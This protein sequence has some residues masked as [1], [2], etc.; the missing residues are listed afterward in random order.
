MKR[1]ALC[2]ML[3]VGLA[4][5]LA[6][7]ATAKDKGDGSH[8]DRRPGTVLYKF[9][10][11]LSTDARAAFAQAL[12][13]R[14]M[15]LDRHLVNGK[16]L[17]VK[18]GN[19]NLETEEQ[20]AEALERSGAVEW[21]EP[22]YVEEAVATPNDPYYANQ[23]QHVNIR[24]TGAWDLTTGGTDVLIA[25]CDTGVDLDHPDLL[26]NLALPGWNTYLNTT[27]CNDT[28]GHGT[29]VAGFAAA[30]GNNGIG[31]A[32][33]AWKVKI[34]PIRITFADGGGSAYVSDIAEAIT[35]GAN[36]GAKVVNVSFSGYSSSAII[37]AAD[38]ARTKGTLVVIAAANDNADLTGY[39]DPKSIVL[40]GATTT[41][42]TRASFSNYGT[43]ID[44]VAPGVNVWSTL[45]GGG[46]GSGSGTSFS[47]PIT[48][49][50]AALVYSVNPA[51]TP[52]EVEGIIEST[53]KDIGAAGEDSVYGFGLIQADA[54]VA[55]AL[56]T[57]GNQRPVA[58]ATATPAQGDIPLAVTFDGSLSSDPD[59]TVVTYA[60]NF[61]DGSAAAYGAT[62]S[63]TY[64]AAGTFTAT[65]T[66][67]DNAGATGATTLTIRTADP[68][69]VNAPSA[70][71]ATALSR[72]VTLSWTDNASNESG[73]YVE[74][75]T[76]SRGVIRFSR[77]ATLGP[78]ATTFQE[79]VAKGT[80]YYRV[81]AY[82]TT[83]GGT[84]VSGYSNTLSLK[85]R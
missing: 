70:L 25:V 78:N 80:Y 68:N 52:A 16:V 58:I 18:A 27:N 43:P 51:F 29:M 12:L 35:Y 34:L 30:A 17:R 6:S 15:K 53:C 32:G 9:K 75:G 49:G 83:S 64:T 5:P 74:R 7:P 4:L 20:M 21:A 33:V 47:S 23:W 22:D 50:L 31:V 38:D 73:F 55:K 71:K 11:G 59:G 2:V 81:Q 10:D 66:V 63:H 56:A 85:V 67:T 82:R 60:W 62:A 19:Q 1:N 13:D 84:T 37:A 61:G 45:N 72:T 14:E 24:S 48:A 57:S 76:S 77:V 69:A 44:V 8:K 26:P 54:A 41:S 3:A 40:A 39:P 79:T 65:L 42:D 46:Y 28:H 36:H